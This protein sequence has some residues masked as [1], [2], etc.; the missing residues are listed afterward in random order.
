MLVSDAEFRDNI[1]LKRALVAL[2]VG[3]SV[4]LMAIGPVQAGELLSFSYGPLIRSLRIS[5]LQAFAKDGSVA[6][7]L[8]FFLQFTPANK[9]ENLRSALLQRADI[10]PLSVS[11]FFNS[12]IGL[13]VVER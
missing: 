9:R 8:A 3:L 7:D 13:D 6:D 4:P 1:V 5:S 10:E 11:Q 12:R 2:F